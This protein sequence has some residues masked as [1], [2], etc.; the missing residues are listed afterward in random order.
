MRIEFRN[1]KNEFFKLYEKYPHKHIINI[2]DIEYNKKQES[3]S[4]SEKSY[5]IGN[6]NVESKRKIKVILHLTK[7]N[8]I[9]FL[10]EVNY[11]YNFFYKDNKPFYY[12]DLDNSRLCEV[13]LLSIKKLTREGTEFFYSSLELE[14]AMID[15]LFFDLNENVITQNFNNTSNVVINVNN[16]L[17]QLVYPKIEIEANQS[18]QDF[19]IIANKTNIRI[20]TNN[21]ASGNKLIIDSKNSE[22]YIQKTNFTIDLINSIESGGFILLEKGNNT[23]NFNFNLNCSGTIKIYY[24]ERYIL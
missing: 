16:V 11:I 1:S 14:F 17:S 5:I 19:E 13:D 24:R 20:L 18:V 12:V 6:E 21:F 22:I 15:N 4:F 7:I 2:D 8:E 9:D 10:N 3:N 23:L